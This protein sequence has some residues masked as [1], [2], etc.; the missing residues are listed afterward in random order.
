MAKLSIFVTLFFIPSLFALDP[1]TKFT[2]LNLPP[3]IIGPE[4]V[5]L[6]RLNQG[7]YTGV[8][9][10]RILVYKGP[11]IG[12]E[13]FAYTAPNRSKQLCDGTT[14]VNL[15]PTCGRALGFSFNN[16]IGVLYIV[17][18][19]LGLFAVGTNGGPATLLANSAD[20]V[21]F[22]FLNGVDVNP[23]TGEVVFTDGSLNFNFRNIVAQNAPSNDSTGRLMIYNPITKQVK[24]LSDGLSDPGGPVFSLDQTFVLYAEFYAKRI[25]KYWLIGPKANTSEVLLNLPG[26]P[27]KIKR[28]TT[29]GEFWVAV[30]IFIDQPQ[31]ITPFGYKINSFGE[32][33]LIKEFRAQYNNTQIN[34]VQE[35]NNGNTLFVGSRTVSYIGIYTKW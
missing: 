20:G 11:N 12:F 18:T 31:S 7:P 4:S 33:L 15:G 1:Y 14:D 35:Y 9:D 10:G 3:G 16:I 32:V 8:S 29:P 5:A 13:D 23:L 24:V 21:R 26:R 2:Q 28:A 17:D 27:I 19:F 25:M 22:N 6:D 34:V 30:N